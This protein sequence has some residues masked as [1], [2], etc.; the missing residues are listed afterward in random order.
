MKDDRLDYAIVFPW[1]DRH[2]DQVLGATYQGTIIDYERF[3]DRGTY[4]H[5]DINRLLITDLMF[6][7]VP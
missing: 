7:L 6:F 1:K 3:G 2:T 5:I 4:K